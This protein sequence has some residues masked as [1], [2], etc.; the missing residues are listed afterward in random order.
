MTVVPNYVS[1]RNIRYNKVN[2]NLENNCTS[3]YS[4]TYDW[5]IAALRYTPDGFARCLVL[6][7]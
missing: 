7:R 4:V 3:V 2:I 5:R 6:C 1:T